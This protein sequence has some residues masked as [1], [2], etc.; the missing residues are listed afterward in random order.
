MTRSRAYAAAEWDAITIWREI[1]CLS[2]STVTLCIAQ[3]VAAV[4]VRNVTLT[5]SPQGRRIG[6]TQ[7][8]NHWPFLQIGAHTRLLLHPPRHL[9]RSRTEFQDSLSQTCKVCSWKWSLGGGNPPRDIHQSPPDWCILWKEAADFH[10]LADNHK[11]SH[12]ARVTS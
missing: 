9:H 1:M 5:L 4:L 7:T 8:P 11:H 10:R 6:A 12:Q 3:A 2:V